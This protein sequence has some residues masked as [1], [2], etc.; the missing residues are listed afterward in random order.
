MFASL[1]GTIFKLISIPRLPFEAISILDDVRPAAPIS[2][3]AIIESPAIN[4]K[5][6][7]RSNFSV[8]GSPT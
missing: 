8:K 3:I 7:S 2:W 1:H 4:S 5:Q 6:A